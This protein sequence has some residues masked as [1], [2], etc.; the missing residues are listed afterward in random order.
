MKPDYLLE[1][2]AYARNCLRVALLFPLFLCEYLLSIFSDDYTATEYSYFTMR[3]LYYLTRG[4]SAR[5]LAF[6]YQLRHKVPQ[7]LANSQDIDIISQ[8][9]IS[10]G[11]WAQP[12]TDQTRS[13][14]S[15]IHNKLIEMP[16]KETLIGKAPG[17]IY[18][19]AKEAISG[20]TISARLEHDRL[21][22]ISIPE[23]W[24]LIK[25]LELRSI[26]CSYLKCDAILTS[27]D[28]WHVVP[29][30]GRKMGCD[31]LYSEA[32]QTFHYDMDWIKFL[33]IFINLT[34]VDENSGPF[35]YMAYSHR[36]R[37]K[38]LYRDGR[39]SSSMVPKELI[40]YA[41]GGAGSFFI[42]D[43][44]GIHRDGRAI[45]KVRHVLQIEFAVSTFGAKI[46]YQKYSGYC[47]FEHITA[48]KIDG[49]NRMYSLFH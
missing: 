40:A 11:Y 5:L 24:Q 35:E 2:K 47:N 31:E 1:A 9:L 14:A 18:K 46:L 38:A 29:L 12:A 13:L 7:N 41:K 16:V 10:K 48:M 22:V 49:K 20:K 4:K 19:N 30:Q 28:S 27:V 21:D 8:S 34:D 44:S 43:T 36:S 37:D 33:K 45:S 15:T 23:V 6:P 25:L 26:A 42:A 3:K 39:H 17:C 32:A